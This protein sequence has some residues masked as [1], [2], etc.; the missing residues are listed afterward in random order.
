MTLNVIFDRRKS[1]LQFHFCE[2]SSGVVVIEKERNTYLH[3]DKTLL[4]EKKHI[5]I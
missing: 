1:L 2:T 4:K 3:D 5:Y